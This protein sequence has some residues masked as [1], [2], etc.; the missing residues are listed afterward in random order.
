MDALEISLIS[1]R[2]ARDQASRCWRAFPPL[3]NFQSC[4]GTSQNFRFWQKKASTCCAIRRTAG[5]VDLRKAIAAVLCDFRAA[6]CHPDRSSSWQ[7]AAGD[8]DQL[9]MAVLIRVKC[10]DRRPC[11]Q[12]TRRVLSLAGVKI[13]PKP[14]DNPGE[15]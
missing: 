4:M 1:G 11:Y 8:A 7:Y 2:R 9:Q 3:T 12:Q 5:D 13:I 6:H 10:V 15:S 14:I